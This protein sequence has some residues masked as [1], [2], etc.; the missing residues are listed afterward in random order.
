MAEI[1]KDNKD[2]EFIKEQI[3]E[4]KRKKIKK[5]ILSVVKTLLLAII[6]GVTAAAAFVVAKPQFDSLMHKNEKTKTPVSFPTPS[7]GMQNPEVTKAPDNT[8]GEGDIQASDDNASTDNGE[9]PTYPVIERIDASLTD[10]IKMYD[11]IR[12]VSSELDKS[13]VNITST[14]TVVDWFN[15]TI[16]KTVDTTGVIVA[17]NNADFL[18]LVSLDRVHDANTIR[19]K[20]T[21]AAYVDAVIQD[22]ETELNLALLAVAKEDIPPI[23]LSNLKVATLGESYTAAVGSPVIAK[24][25]PNGHPNSVEVGMITSKGSYVKITDNSLDLFNINITDN[26]D[27]DGVIVNLK[28]EIIG[29]ITRTLKEDVNKEISTAIGISKIKSYIEKMGNQQPRICFGIKA[30]DMTENA[31]LEHNVPNGIYV[32]EVLTDTPAFDAGM[33]RGDIILSIND[34][35]IISTNNFYYTIS[36]MHPD[37]A[38]TV[39]I[40]RTSGTEDKEMELRIVLGKKVQ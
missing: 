27:S 39:K 33:K 3:I 10:Y 34:Q 15:K 25:C 7:T 38:V 37:T 35:N 13:I 21:E 29:I 9:T 6:F 32:C 11:E 24:G 8:S 26:S 12:K 28:G 14:F 17:D 20:F 5:R 16:N 23:Y 30:D 36:T 22:Y 18:I 31:K 2:F 19:L 1:E 4:K 40:K